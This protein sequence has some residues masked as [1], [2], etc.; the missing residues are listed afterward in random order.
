MNSEIIFNILNYLN[1]KKRIIKHYFTDC[2]I[3][4]VIE[5]TEEFAKN[6]LVLIYDIDEYVQEKKNVKREFWVTLAKLMIYIHVYKVFFMGFFDDIRIRLL[7]MDYTLNSNGNP[8]L[9][10]LAINSLD[11]ILLVAPFLFQY[12]EMS[13]QMP[14]WKIY[15][16]I[17]YRI[18]KYPLNS[19]NYRKFC[20]YHKIVSLIICNSF[21]IPCAIFCTVC[22]FLVFCSYPRNG[23]EIY[24]IF[25]LIL[26]NITFFIAYYY[27]AACIMV[28]YLV[29]MSST[30]Y[31][32]YKFEEINTKIELS[33]KQMN[34][35]LLMNAIH[36]HNYVE[37]LDP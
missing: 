21:F 19:N 36:E 2:N 5:R 32:K 26:G 6:K 31:L 30:L 27:A 10:S 16:L 1:T 29:W 25:G 12:L 4:E 17:K 18:I 13:R 15:H 8:L 3:R 35:R 34:I 20:F 11:L 37:R 24:S 33:L 14:I 23:F 22:H 28:I 9:Y 7:I